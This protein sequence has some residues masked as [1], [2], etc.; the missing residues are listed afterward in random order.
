MHV[1]NR[2]NKIKSHT[3]CNVFTINLN[4]GTNT[5]WKISLIIR[6]T[7]CVWF[8]PHVDWMIRYGWMLVD[9]HPIRTPHFLVLFYV[10]DGDD[11]SMTNWKNKNKKEKKKK[12]KEERWG[13]KQKA[14]TIKKCPAEH[15]KSF[16]FFCSVQK[17][18][19]TNR[20]KLKIRVLFK[21][22]ER[23][24]GRGAEL[25]KLR[26]ITNTGL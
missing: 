17:Q 16:Y 7:Y 3:L 1:I 15:W 19:C 21:E 9:P 20:T 2:K 26:I 13:R 18:N 11:S 10:N 12:K 5:K 23:G 22:W 14:I 8:F 25:V 4:D 24:R 6:R